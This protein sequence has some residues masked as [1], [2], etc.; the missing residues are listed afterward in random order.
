MQYRSGLLL[1]RQLN[2]LATSGDRKGRRPRTTFRTAVLRPV[3][4]PD[5]RINSQTNWATLL[6]VSADK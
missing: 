4:E 5:D 6:P 3:A 2:P 1:E